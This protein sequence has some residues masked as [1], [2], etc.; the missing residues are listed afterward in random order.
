ME[1]R[2]ENIIKETAATVNDIAL[3]LD[4]PLTFLYDVLND[5]FEN[6]EED[7]KRDTENLIAMWYSAQHYKVY[8]EAVIDYILKTSEQLNSLSAQLNSLHDK[9]EVT[10]IPLLVESR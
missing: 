1:N 7:E 2:N 3:K 6:C 8:I 4:K 9:L 5:F 10:Y